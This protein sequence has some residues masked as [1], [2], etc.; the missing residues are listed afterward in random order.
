M[1]CVLATFE[2]IFFLQLSDFFT[3]T[4]VNF[5]KSKYANTLQKIRPG[6]AFGILARS[7]RRYLL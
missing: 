6:G 3:K 7:R 1:K 4:R 5:E 2:K